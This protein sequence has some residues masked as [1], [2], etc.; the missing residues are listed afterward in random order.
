MMVWEADYSS[1]IRLSVSDSGET[2]ALP[3]QLAATTNI[4]HS[5][6]TSEHQAWSHV[7]QVLSYS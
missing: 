5:I 4:V 2:S 3:T 7:F 6:L 1:C